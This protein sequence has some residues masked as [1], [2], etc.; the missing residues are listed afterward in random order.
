MNTATMAM[1]KAEITKLVPQSEIV[2]PARGTTV[3]PSR[4]PSGIRRDN[5]LRLL[6]LVVLALFMTWMVVSVE[7][8]THEID[9]TMDRIQE[10]MLR[11]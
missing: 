6:L 10:S 5:R 8:A 9:E 4:Q 3:G 11:W 7:S 1:N 2:E